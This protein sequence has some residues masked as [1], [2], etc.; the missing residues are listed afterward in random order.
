VSGKKSGQTQIRL[1]D[2]PAAE[3]LEG[4]RKTVTVLFA[5]IKGSMDLEEG[6]D[7]E[8]AR[9]IVDPALKL[10]IDA[11]HHYDGYVAQSTGDGIFA[12]FGAPVAHED[13]P[14]RA[15]HAALR[16]QEDLH[17]FAA[18]QRESRQTA[19]EA[20]IG[21][22]TGEVVLRSIQTTEGRDEYVP[23]GHAIGLA[24][25]LQ[26]LAPVGSIAASETT[27]K[28][29]EGYFN[30]RS[31]GPTR[32][33]G[34]SETLDVYEVMGLGRL[35]TRLQRSVARGLTKFIGRDDEMR[36]LWNRWEVAREGEGQ[37]VLIVG[38]A[39]IGKS[40]VMHQF[41]ERLGGSVVRWLEGAAEPYYQN[42]PF[43]AVVAIVN[44][45]FGVKADPTPDERLDQL[46]RVLKQN[47][48]N[49]PEEVAL[50]AQLLNLPLGK[51]YSES[52][53]PPERARKRLLA[54]LVKTLFA[55]AASQPMV[56][57]WKT[58]TGPTH[59]HWNSWD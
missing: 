42:T 40:R 37:M 28:L 20:R 58:C 25:R 7:P 30:F 27:Q 13:D 41:H 29:C 6:I 31:L 54:T 38:E 45:A 18:K 48:I 35:R 4:E 47:G 33:K 10:M 50:L 24:A 49:A 53:L 23:V 46:Q 32:V 55:L 16:M 1:T 44:Q 12:L 21:I 22:H 59:R 56:L 34:V 19:I 14:Q 52:K 17:R 39:G 9:A 3:N 26:A 2:A 43:H 57:R 15:L 8:D 51:R 36:T 5:D 11:V